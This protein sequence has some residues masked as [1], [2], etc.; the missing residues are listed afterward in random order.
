MRFWEAMNDKYGFEDGSAYPDGVELYRDVYCKG[1]NKIA[2]TKNSDFRVVPFDRAGVHNFCL[3]MV[4]PKAW[5]EGV[6]LPKQEAGKPWIGVN[7]DEIPDRDSP[8]PE[9]DDALDD[10]ISEAMEMNLDEFLDVKVVV[11]D[12][13]EKFLK[14]EYVPPPNPGD[15]D[16]FDDD[17]E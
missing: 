11:S 17:E 9:P 2:E 13:F 1:V 7:W 5:Y 12:D 10:A 16:E 4:V 15:D 8:E 14:D 6:F 3:W